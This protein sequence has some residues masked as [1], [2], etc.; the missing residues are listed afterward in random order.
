MSFKIALIFIGIG[1][2]LNITK[3]VVSKGVQGFVAWIIHIFGKNT[4]TDHKL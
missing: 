3:S 4:A 2:L 1:V